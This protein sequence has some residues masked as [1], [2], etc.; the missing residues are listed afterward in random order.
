MI[1]K[2]LTILYLVTFTTPYILEMEVL[3]R[4]KQC[5]TEKF[6]KNEPLSVRG[7]VI[8]ADR[9][10]FSLYITIET[11]GHKLLTHKKYES[12]ST[13]T[14]LSYNNEEDQELNLCIDN[15]EPYTI[16]IE[17]NVKY[18]SGLGDADSSPTKNVMYCIVLG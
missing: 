18:G 15:F 6:K 7:T 17:M 10:E 11:Q 1:I 3:G 2:F 12:T 14:V 8:S 4:K 9:A 13:S 16:I 5:I